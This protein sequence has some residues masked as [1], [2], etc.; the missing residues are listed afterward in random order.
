M[1]EQTFDPSTQA[2]NK[3][4]PFL[5]RMNDGGVLGR[6]G[7]VDSEERTRECA[8]PDAFSGGMARGRGGSSHRTS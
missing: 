1:S 4:R 5:P 2:P 6:L 8:G 3:E 7:E